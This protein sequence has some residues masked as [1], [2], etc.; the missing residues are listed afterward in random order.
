M[1][2]L[3]NRS[4]QE[5]Q[6][7]LL[8]AIAVGGKTAKQVSV[9]LPVFLSMETGTTPF[10]RI[11]NMIKKHRLLWCLKKARLGKYK[12]LNRAFREVVD[13]SLDL[14]NCSV[15]ELERLYG[16]G[17]KTSRYFILH[18]RENANVAA[19]DTHLL[20][21]LSKQGYDAP[22]HTPAS[23]KRYAELEAAFLH[24][25]SERGFSPAEL[26]LRIWQESSASP[27][28]SHHKIQAAHYGI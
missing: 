4:T 20:R 1:S 10:S 7:F 26:D 27:I 18:T 3:N 2:V 6:E 11:R 23:T 15:E 17:P 25:A 21:W 22:N 19:L 9:A 16:I 28:P 13:C 5:L 14:H 24:E 12:R 8:F